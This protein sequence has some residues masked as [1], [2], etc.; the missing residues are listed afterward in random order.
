M[1]LTGTIAYAAIALSFVSGWILHG[2]YAAPPDRTRVEIVNGWRI[3]CTQSS[4]PNAG[5]EMSQDVGDPT[6]HATVVRFAIGRRDDKP[7][8]DVIVPLNVLL[9]AKL[10]LK[11]NDGS[12][13]AFAYHFCDGSGCVATIYPDG[14]LY[15]AVLRAKQ[16]TV[17][18][19]ALSGKVIGYKLS[20]DGF[21][22][23]V[24]AFRDARD[25]QTSFLMR[26]LL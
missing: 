8:I 1:K 20:M 2:L 23:A 9:A 18:F 19:A 3:A 6:T 12:M 14:T 26:V 7:V 21:A 10:G 15:G 5:C 16:I 17:A 24:S 4:A 22:G 11:L 25:R 13:Q